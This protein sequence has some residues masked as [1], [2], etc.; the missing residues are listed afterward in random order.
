[1]EVPYFTQDRQHYRTKRFPWSG[2]P[3]SLWLGPS[4]PQLPYGLWR[5]PREGDAVILTEGESDTI[6]LALA[7]PKVPVLG[8][9][10]S[11][12]WQREWWGYVADYRRVYLSFDA[13][14]GGRELFDAVKADVPEYRQVLLPEGADTRAFL[15]LLGR[16]AYKVLI[17]VAD[18]GWEQRQAWAALDS[19]VRRRRQVEIAWER[20]HAA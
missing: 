5:L 14:R 20:R 7:F 11:G 9:P 1:M 3:R 19:A 4:K 6:A 8:L 2:E 17:E 13:D 18:R 12:S 10:G 15:Q 16:V